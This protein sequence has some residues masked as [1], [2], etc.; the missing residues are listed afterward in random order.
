MNVPELR[1]VIGVINYLGRFVP[2]LAT[3]MQPMTDLLKSNRA[4]TWGPSQQEAFAKVQEIISGSAAL[5]FYDP[6]TLTVVCTDTSSYGIGG[7]LMQGHGGQLRP[8]TFCSR[9]LT[10][11]EDK[12]AQIEKEYLVAV[13][14]CARLSCYLVGLST[15][16]LLIDLK[17]L[18][19]LINQRGLDKT[20]LRCQRLLMRLMRFY[21]LAEHVTCQ[22]NVSGRY[23]V[24]KHSQVWRGTRYSGRC[25]RICWLGWIYKASHG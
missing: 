10:E 19:L 20:P 16:K 8:V 21:P 18:V 15:F 12:Y 5:V 17:L 1:R 9:T 23:S 11:T 4:W 2:N 13:W 7:V 22:A 14:T 24:K 6:K 25:S 3:I